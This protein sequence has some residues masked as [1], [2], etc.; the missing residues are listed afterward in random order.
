MCSHE[1][2]VHRHAYISNGELCRKAQARCSLDYSVYRNMVQPCHLGWGTIPCSGL[3][4]FGR[5]HAC[6]PIFTFLL[7]LLLPPAAS[8]PQYSSF[9]TEK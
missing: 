1:T 3:I 7:V 2:H 8:L 9:G 5:K 4:Y 6:S